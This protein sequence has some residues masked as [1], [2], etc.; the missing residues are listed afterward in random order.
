V[1]PPNKTTY[2]VGESLSTSGMV[3]TATYNDNSTK[4][5]TSSCSTSG[6]DS[7]TSG[8]KN[9]TVSYT[10]NGTTRTDQ[11]SV[12]IN[13]VKTLSRID[14]SNI[15]K[16]DYNIGDDLYIS[17]MIVTVT[18]SD[19]ST[20]TIN[21]WDISSSCVISGFD[22]STA[23]KKTVTISYSENG[24][25]KTTQFTVEVS[26][27]VLTSIYIDDRYYAG[28][29][30][31]EDIVVVWARYSDGTSRLIAPEDWTLTWTS[32]TSFTAS[33][34]EN[35]V[36]KTATYTYATKPWFAP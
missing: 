5:V 18:Y 6:F 2:N 23:G 31:Y 15:Y 34:T 30:G 33:Y 21:S 20:K 25:T 32:D 1:T 8:T 24:V 17:G 29:P 4:N 10:E 22:S 14:V 19:N 7:S 12:T 36:T 16:T 13:A 11:F 35:G 28:T 26:S 3:V 27:R 9:V